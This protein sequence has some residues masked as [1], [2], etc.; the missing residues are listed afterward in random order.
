MERRSISLIKAIRLEESIAWLS[1]IIP[2]EYEMFITDD[3]NTELIE[4][5]NL[6]NELASI[7]KRRNEI[8]NELTKTK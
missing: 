3:N 8:I 7:N 6:L 4:E 5:T 1:T 2:Q